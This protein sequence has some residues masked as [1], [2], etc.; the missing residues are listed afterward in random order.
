M[1][2]PKLLKS[3]TVL[4]STRELRALREVRN[5][6]ARLIDDGEILILNADD[7]AADRLIA[8]CRRS[9]E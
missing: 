9:G 6:V 5:I 2:P 1:S 3:P 7:K 4:V 8:A